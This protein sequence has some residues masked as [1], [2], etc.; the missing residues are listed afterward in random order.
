MVHI[1]Q[2]LLDHATP[3]VMLGGGQ[4]ATSANINQHRLEKWTVAEGALTRQDRL[5]RCTRCIISDTIA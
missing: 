1:W 5:T 3:N 2:K 4:P